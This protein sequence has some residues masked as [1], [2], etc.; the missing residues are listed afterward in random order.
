M[1]TRVKL[2]IVANDCARNLDVSIFLVTFC[3]L[4]HPCDFFHTIEAGRSDIA[5]GSN[6]GGLVGKADRV[7]AE[8]TDKA[9]ADDCAGEHLCHSGEKCSSGISES[10]RHHSGDV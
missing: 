6:L 9:E 8:L 1:R 7:I 10:L 3:G 2:E 5:A 4:Q